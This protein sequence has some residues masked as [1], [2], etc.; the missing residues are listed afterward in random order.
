MLT[1][2]SSTVLVTGSAAISNKEKRRFLKRTKM[3]QQDWQSGFMKRNT[4]PAL[5]KTPLIH[6]QTCIKTAGILLEN[7]GF[8]NWIRLEI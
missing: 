7:C 3:S 2:D 6:S 5:W 8:E 4:I 1:N